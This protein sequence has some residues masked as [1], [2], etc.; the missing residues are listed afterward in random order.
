MFIWKENK[1]KLIKER[2][3][4]KNKDL[5]ISYCWKIIIIKVLK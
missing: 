4:Y 3:V 2:L 5:D 1:E